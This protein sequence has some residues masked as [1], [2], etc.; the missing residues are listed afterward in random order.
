MSENLAIVIITLA[1][2]LSFCIT[3]CIFIRAMV[4]IVEHTDI[5]TEHKVSSI[6]CQ[7]EKK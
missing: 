4:T 5:T 2:L 1:V 6:N 7:T 3:T